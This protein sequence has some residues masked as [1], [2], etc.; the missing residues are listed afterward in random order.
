MKRNPLIKYALRHP[1][2]SDLAKSIFFH[3]I[4]TN[5]PLYK[6]ISLRKAEKR[7]KK[8]RHRIPGVTIETTLNCN[9]KCVM[10]YHSV[11][12]LK[13]TMAMD[14]FKKI[15]DDCAR[16]GLTDVGL[17]IYGEPL[18]DRFF[19]ERIDYLRKY[20]MEYVFFTNGILLNKKT[21]DELFRMGGLKMIN[22]SVCGYEKDV[23][24]K[25]MPG[26]DRDVAY[27]NILS[28]LEMKNRSKKDSPIV[29]VSTVK[30]HLNQKDM[31]R[32]IRFWQRQKGINKIITADL[33]N[34]VGNDRS[35]ISPIGK[36][37][38]KKNWFAPCSQLWSEMYVYYDGRVAPCCLDADLR[39][40]I[41]GDLNKETL[42]DIRDGKKLAHLRRLHLDDKRQSHPVCGNCHHNSLWLFNDKYLHLRVS[43]KTRPRA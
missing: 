38:D 3:P 33:W 43:K 9:A 36:R 29:S 37:Y 17:S 34:R 35:K 25:I 21:A 26:L 12:D 11:K 2:L 19:L 6:R 5:L 14:L 41:I 15:I 10:C 27:H 42:A 8:R 4:I 7:D 16:N 24:E 1:H 28:F 18:M 22:F 30:T 39:Q 20:G 31:P 32:F 23:Y 13:G 40:L